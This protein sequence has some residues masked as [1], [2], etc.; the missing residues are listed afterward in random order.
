MLPLKINNVTKIFKN[1]KGEDFKAV[2][3]ISLDIEAGKIH[4]LLGPN[5]A[6]KSTLINMISGILLPSSGEIDVFGLNVK[7]DPNKTKQLIGVVPQEI[8][9]EMAFTVEEVL[10]YFGGMYGVPMGE[11]KTRIKQVLEDLGLEDKINERARNLSGGMKRRLMV[12]KAILHKPKLLIL[13][14]P[15]AGVDVS[16]RQKIWSLVQRLNKEGTT[17]VFTTHYLEEAEQLCEYITL[18]DHGHIIKNGKLKDIQQEFSKNTIHFELFDKT[19]PLL[20]GASEVGVEYEYPIS[21]DLGT[22]MANLTKHYGSNIK[23]IR[24]EAASLEHIFL[25]LTANK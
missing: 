12:A 2:D 20:A 22:D 15:T 7:K 6:G 18:V 13:D 4:G 24:S 21:H 8:V 1:S 23:A 3:N 17:I 5:G 16:L 19:A 10:Y 9:V 14:E 25:K 11:R